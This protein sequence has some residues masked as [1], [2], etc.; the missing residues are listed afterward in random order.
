MTGKC[1]IFSGG[2]CLRDYF[3]LTRTVCVVAPWPPDQNNPRD[4]NFLFIPT[5]R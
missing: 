1:Y 4:V 3:L 2:L 5:E